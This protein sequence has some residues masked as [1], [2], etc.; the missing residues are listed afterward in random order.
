MKP[1]Q[2]SDPRARAYP[3]YTF[4]FEALNFSCN[5]T[6]R[7]RDSSTI[8]VPASILTYFPERADFPQGSCWTGTENDDL[9][10][11]NHGNWWIPL[12]CFLLGTTAV[13]SLF[14]SPSFRPPDPWPLALRQF[15]ALRTPLT[16]WQLPL[17]R[18]R[19]LVIKRCD[20]CPRP[21]ARPPFRP[22]PCNWPALWR[23]N[24]TACR[25]DG[26]SLEP[27]ICG[28][29][30]STRTHTRTRNTLFQGPSLAKLSRQVHWTIKTL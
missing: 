5:Q 15:H 26:K 23:L 17:E 16:S 25:R 14:S 7:T 8:I 12:G 18:W 6:A 9:I 13:L 21:R 24:E 22:A 20:L 1:G 27:D 4:R 3:P 2:E 10:Y 29:V 30:R 28:S 11:G 19:L